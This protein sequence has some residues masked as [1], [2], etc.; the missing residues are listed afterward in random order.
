MEIM[1]LTEAEIGQLKYWKF[2]LYKNII[3]K[4]I[5]CYGSP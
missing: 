2:G 4:V 1:L 5:D 3:I